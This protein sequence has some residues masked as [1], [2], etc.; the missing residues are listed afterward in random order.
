MLDEGSE[1]DSDGDSVDRGD[2]QMEAAANKPRASRRW[3]RLLLPAVAVTALAFVAGT[4]AAGRGDDDD[5]ITP[6]ASSTAPVFAD[7]SAGKDAVDNILTRIAAATTALDRAKARLAADHSRIVATIT[8]MDF[9]ASELEAIAV[10]LRTNPADRLPDTI[11]PRTLDE[12]ASKF[13]LA[14]SIWHAKA[15]C[16]RDTLNSGVLFAQ[17]PAACSGVADPDPMDLAI[18]AASTLADFSNMG[19]VGFAEIVSNG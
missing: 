17:D 13:S 12:I 6:S 16:Y 14:A 11:S 3:A 2:T 9:T 10:I 18:T 5:A 1:A 15:S 8:Q 4:W 7:P 19:F